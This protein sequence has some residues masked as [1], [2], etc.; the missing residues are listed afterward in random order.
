LLFDQ[1]VNI[2]YQFKVEVLAVQVL[3]CR[4]RIKE[5]RYSLVDELRREVSVPR[6]RGDEKDHFHRPTDL[7]ILDQGLRTEYDDVLCV[8]V[9]VCVCECNVYV[10][11]VRA[12]NVSVRVVPTYRAGRERQVG[13][14]AQEMLLRLFLVASCN[15]DS[16]CTEREDRKV[17]K[18]DRSEEER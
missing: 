11:D 16:A 18:N 10:R 13:G 6:G 4:K 9:C 17:T 7:D 15:V 5:K 12:C 3:I 2:I 14:L 8:C 1:Y